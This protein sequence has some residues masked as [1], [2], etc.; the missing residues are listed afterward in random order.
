MN[1]INHTTALMSTQTFSA[2]SGEETA[3]EWVHLLPAVGADG[4]ETGDARGPY[5]IPNIEAMITASMLD[6]KRLPIDENHATDLAAPKGLP[7]PARGWIVELQSRDDGIW[8]RVEWTDTGKEL[9]SSHAYRGISPVIVHD[10]DDRIL[11]ILRASLVNKPNLRG[12]T[13]LHQQQGNQMDW[14]KFLAGLL[15]LGDD[16]TEDQI[17]SALKSKLTAKADGGDKGK[18]AKALQSQ[19]SEI[20]VALGVDAD[21]D[22]TAILDAA[23]STGA[24]PAEIVALQ[25]E[26]SGL[27]TKLNVLTENTSRDKATTFVDG[28][29]S[30]G[31]VGVKPLRDH[32]ISMHMEDADRVEKEVGAMPVL[33]GKTTMITPP[34]IKDGKIALNAEQSEVA[35]QLGIDPED[36]AKTLADER[37]NEEAL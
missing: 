33:N 28:A 7:S 8:G 18:E 34:E 35:R 5:S 25:S 3:P 11:R 13:A 12:L 21:A 6:A 23:K 24:K 37:A 4:I 31:R 10:E 30:E 16:A 17:K 26:I 29:I 9:V 20:G 27:T 15:G 19:M 22:V 2:E 36:Y 14:M 32:Y 1:A